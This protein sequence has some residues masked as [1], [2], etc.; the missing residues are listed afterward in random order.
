[1]KYKYRK[2]PDDTDPSKRWTARPILQVRLYYGPNRQDIRCLVDSGADDCLF[3]TSVGDRLGID[4]Q[5]G[6][7]KR[8]AGIAAGH[9]VEAYMHAL[10]MQ[11]QG[12]SEKI[13]LEAGFTDSEW[14]YGILGQ[15]G[16]FANYRVTFE[17]FRGRFEV[18]SRSKLRLPGT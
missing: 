14:V 12:F 1:M 4:V 6:R 10:Q 17:R 11:I 2:I 9:F 8:F 15:S 16:F 7:L 18:T 5:A 13:D 3:H